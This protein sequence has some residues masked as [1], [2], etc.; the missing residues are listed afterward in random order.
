[1]LQFLKAQM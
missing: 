1:M